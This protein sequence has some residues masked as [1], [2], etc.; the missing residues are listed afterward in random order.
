MEKH[1]QVTEEIVLS[2]VH[3]SFK[4]VA[5][6]HQIPIDIE[7]H[8]PVAISSAYEEDSAVVEANVFFLSRNGTYTSYAFVEIPLSLYNIHSDPFLEFGGFLTD[9]VGAE[10]VDENTFILP[11]K[12]TTAVAVRRHRANMPDA[13]DTITY[14]SAS[15]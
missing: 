11:M 6:E 14:L 10:H 3:H 5:R 2:E 1:E 7:S 13:G 9:T 4:V 15:G 12:D 8:E